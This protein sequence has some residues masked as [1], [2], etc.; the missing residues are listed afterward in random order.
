MLLQ[1]LLVTMLQNVLEQILEKAHWSKILPLYI[2]SFGGLA[3]ILVGNMVDVG[4][5]YMYYVPVNPQS[6]ECVTIVESAWL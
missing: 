1:N 3:L 2:L 5:I 6:G 4:H